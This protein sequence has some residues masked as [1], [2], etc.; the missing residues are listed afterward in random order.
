V[1]IGDFRPEDEA[2]EIEVDAGS[3][4]DGELAVVVTVSVELVVTSLG[5]DAETAQALSAR[6][7]GSE[8][9]D[10]CDCRESA[11]TCKRHHIPLFHAEMLFA[12]K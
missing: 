10:Q 8:H 7:L 1:Q 11:F 4:A 6:L 5:F 12:I 2:A 9:R 3:A